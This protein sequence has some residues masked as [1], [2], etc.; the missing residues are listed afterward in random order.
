MNN[1]LDIIRQEIDKIDSNIILLLQER[2][3]RCV[4]ISK[5]KPII[6]DP[7]REKQILDKL[8]SDAS[9][10]LDKQFITNLYNLI[11]TQSKKLQQQE[12]N[13]ENDKKDF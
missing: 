3:K 12:K 1:S 11:F 8:S 9:E 13:S 2:M 6:Y 4:K 5:L 7:V 10:M